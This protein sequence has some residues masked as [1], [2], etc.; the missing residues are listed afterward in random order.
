MKKPA[1]KVDNE[2][3]LASQLRAIDIKDRSFRQNLTDDQKKKFSPYLMMRYAASCEGPTDLQTYYLLATNENVN[4][5][6]FAPEIN[7][8]PELQWL[9]CTTVSPGMGVKRHYWFSSSTKVPKNKYIKLVAEKL[10]QWKMAD[11]EH[12]IAINT[13]KDIEEWLS[14]FGE[15][16][17]K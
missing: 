6:F 13:D 9:M 10:P 1:K 4:K 5:N 12:F 17:K 14:Q 2:I 8:H 16:F 15:E 3:S 7:K 11:I